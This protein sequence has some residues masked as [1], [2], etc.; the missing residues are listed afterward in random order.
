[1]SCFSD[2]NYI[3]SDFGD[4]LLFSLIP[5]ILF[6]LRFNNGW[7]VKIGRG[8]DIYKPVGKYTIGSHSYKFRPCKKTIVDIF[9]LPWKIFF[10]KFPVFQPGVLEFIWKKTM[11][12]AQSNLIISIILII[13]IVSYISQTFRQL[14]I[15][16]SICAEYRVICMWEKYLL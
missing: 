12:C 5:W 1:M 7:L 15:Y 6:S 16:V 13:Y 11:I 4:Q 14:I 9:K 2:V 3:F 10:E 8:L